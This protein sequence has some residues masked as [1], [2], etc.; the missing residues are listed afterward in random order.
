MKN[1]KISIATFFGIGRFPIAPGTLAS[2][3][4]TGVI[5]VLFHFT[6]PSIITRSIS[7]FLIF[8]IGIPCADA[9]EKFFGKKDPGIIVIDEVA[10]QMITFLFLYPD[11]TRRSILI[12]ITGF[13]LFRIFDILKPFPVNLADRLNGGFG[14]MLDDIVA[15]LYSL[16]FLHLLIRLFN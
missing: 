10:G 12:F 15:G 13:L 11:F 4:T 9:A 1:I 8:L 7:V 6:N 3:V 5:F 14:I 2:L 16:G